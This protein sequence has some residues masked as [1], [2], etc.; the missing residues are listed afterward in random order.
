MIGSR[1]RGDLLHDPAV[2]GKGWE[3]CHDLTGGRSLV[4]IAGELRERERA[5]QEAR[6]RAWKA[7]QRRSWLRRAAGWLRDILRRPDRSQTGPPARGFDDPEPPL[8]SAWEALTQA[9]AI[10]RRAGHR[11]LADTLHAVFLLDLTGNLADMAPLVASVRASLQS[12]L[13]DDPGAV[14]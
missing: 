1:A 2:P 12:A 5:R 6:R 4:C 9:Q 8:S 10:A 13:G 11:E 7:R 3:G 14:N